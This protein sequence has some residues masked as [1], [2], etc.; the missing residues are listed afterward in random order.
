MGLSVYNV[1]GV[2][3]PAQTIAQVVPNDAGL[4]I[5]AQVSP[6]DAEDLRV[7]QEAT[8]RF[9]SLHERNLP[10]IKGRITNVSAD[11]FTDEKTGQRYFKIEAKVSPETLKIVQQARGDRPGLRPGLPVEMV[12]PLKQRTALQYLLEPLGQTFFKSFREQ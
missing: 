8:V 2:V 4:V 12:V 9:S 11:S 7:G 10:T 1:G 5:Q 6:S 3:Q